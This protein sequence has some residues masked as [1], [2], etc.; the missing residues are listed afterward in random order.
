[1]EELIR[2]LSEGFEAYLL[3]VVQMKGVRGVAP[4]DRTHPAFGEALRRAAKAGVQILAVDCRVTPDELFADQSLS[5]FLEDFLIN[6]LIPAKLW[7]TVNN[8]IVKGGCTHAG[9]Y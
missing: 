4:N 3:F 6:M 1:M 5:I 8:R 2:C 9:E 7:Y